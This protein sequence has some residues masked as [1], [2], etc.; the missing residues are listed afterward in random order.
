MSNN[1]SCQEAAAT[2]VSIDPA[3]HGLG[4]GLWYGA[5]LVGAQYIPRPVRADRRGP[6]NWLE[7][8]RAAR[9]FFLS[10]LGTLPAYVVVEHMEVYVHRGQ[11]NVGKPEDILE[12]QAVSAALVTLAERDAFSYLPKQWKGQVP[13]DVMA[14][15][16]KGRIEKAGW[17]DRVAW[18][19]NAKTD[20]DILHG[21]GLGLFHLHGKV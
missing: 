1:P 3:L 6:N 17:S 10:A 5:E 13:K 4:V 21:V 20:C 16:I 15:R 7:Q 11:R 19:N 14:N 8:W 2:L 9:A 18:T 12:L